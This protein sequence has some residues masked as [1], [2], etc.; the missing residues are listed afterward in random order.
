MTPSLVI[1]WIAAGC[2]GMAAPAATLAAMYWVA[3]SFWRAHV[4]FET[5]T[6]E[7]QTRAASVSV[8]VKEW[9]RDLYQKPR[10]VCGVGP[11]GRHDST[12]PIKSSYKQLAA[13]RETAQAVVL[14]SDLSVKP[15][16]SEILL[17]D[18]PTRY[19]P[20]FTGDYDV[21]VKSNG[22][23][24]WTGNPA[25]ALHDAYERHLK[26]PGIG[27]HLALMN[28]MDEVMPPVDSSRSLT[29]GQRQQLEVD[30][31]AFPRHAQGCS[32]DACWY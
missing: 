17:A 14:D 12:C 18:G 31:S 13:L 2:F 22:K 23:L 28:A 21:M 7:A 1:Y 25:S 26:T 30:S 29:A 9:R 8:G 4:V 19:A 20:G 15:V 16:P 10:C 5:R 27:L 24:G 6:L 3:W 32:C 11:R